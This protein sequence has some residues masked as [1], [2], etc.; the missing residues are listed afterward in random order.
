MFWPFRRTPRGTERDWFRLDARCGE[1]TTT[2]LWDPRKTAVII[3]DMWEDHWCK[4]AAQRCA[5]LA[6]RV[7]EF[8][9][10]ARARGALVIHA[11][12]D[13]MAFYAG[14][15]QRRRAQRARAFA[16]PIPITE[17]QT[18]PTREPDLPIDDSDGGCDD[19]PPCPFYPSWNRQHPAVMIAEQDIISDS[20]QEIYN[21]LVRANIRNV[22]IAGVHTNKCVLIRSFGIRQMVMLGMNVILVRD[23]TD[24][25]YNP[26]KPPRV[27]HDRGTELVIEHIEKYWC[28]SIISGDVASPRTQVPAMPTSASG[29]RLA[30]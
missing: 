30:T 21:V 10:A 3:C 6:P 9:R 28:P 27:G 1:V 8:A 15:P 18:D 24:S 12:S 4:S 5:A 26:S 25:L 16:P 14:M 20:G 7:D 2:V 22:F 29:G 13:T 11:P 17:R 19:A 23:L